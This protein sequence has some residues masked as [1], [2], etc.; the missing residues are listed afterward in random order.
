MQDNKTIEVIV[1][2]IDNLHELL[3][4]LRGHVRRVYRWVELICLDRIVETVQLGYIGA[5][6]IEVESLEGTRTVVLNH[7]YRATC[8]NQHH[9][10]P[11]I[12]RE[13]SHDAKIIFY[14]QK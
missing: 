3:P 4:H 5:Q 8:V 13:I 6:V 9:T 10:G 11:G 1:V 2:V 12:E 14:L 7:T